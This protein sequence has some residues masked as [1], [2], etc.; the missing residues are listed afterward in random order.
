MLA[1]QQ[2]LGVISHPSNISDECAVTSRNALTDEVGHA[3]QTLTA[4]QRESA[5]RLACSTQYQTIERLISR[6]RGATAMEIITRCGTV[7]PHKRLSE[8]RDRGWR[9]TRKQ[10][11]G[12]SYGAYFGVA[13]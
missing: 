1:Q 13:P 7:C 5:I 8:L 11:A 2:P 4:D 12:K 9:I 10:I 3:A 6:K